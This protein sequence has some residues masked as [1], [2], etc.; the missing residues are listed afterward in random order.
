[1]FPPSR[2]SP[3]ADLPCH[4]PCAPPCRP[5]SQA[6]HAAL[7]L[8]G[9]AGSMGSPPKGHTDLVLALPKTGFSISLCHLLAND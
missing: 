1:M 5:R 6:H 8:H 9:S 7:P 3:T 4:Y 2:L